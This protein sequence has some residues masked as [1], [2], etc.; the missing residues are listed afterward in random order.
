MKKED[1]CITENY[2]LIEAIDSIKNNRNRGAIIVNGENKVIGFISQG[3]ILEM[4]VK[5]ISLYASVGSVMKPSFYYAYENESEKVKSLFKEKL[6]TIL[7]IVD[8]EFILQDVI[9]LH[10]IMQKI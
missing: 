1:Y 9:T 10:D 6:I 5:G 2:T 4:L 8:E 7:P 3:D